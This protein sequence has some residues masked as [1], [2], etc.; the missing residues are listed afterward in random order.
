[1]NV[2]EGM[3]TAVDADEATS[4]AGA[5]GSRDVADAHGTHDSVSMS[6]ACDPA[7]ALKAPKVPLCRKRTAQLVCWAALAVLCTVFSRYLIPNP[8]AY[9][10][11]FAPL[12]V[13]CLLFLLFR[14]QGAFVLAQLKGG[15][16]LLV[17][18][19][20][21]SLMLSCA[22]VMGAW[23]VSE[24]A[25]AVSPLHA[26]AVVVEAVPILVGF[27]LLMDWLDKRAVRKSKRGEAHCSKQEGW[28]SCGEPRCDAIALR[29]NSSSAERPFFS[30][31]PF[32]LIVFAVMV[33]CWLPVFLA[34]YPGFFCYDMT[35]GD[36]AEWDQY[37]VGHFSAHQPVAHTLLLGALITLGS[38][39]FGSFNAGVAA[40]VVV[41]AVVVAAIF[42]F[43]LRR[44]WSL[45]SSRLLTGCSLAYLALD[46]LVSLFV[47]CTTKDVLFSAF[48]VLLATLLLS[49]F[50]RNAPLRIA[51]LLSIGLCAVAVGV[52]RPNGLLAVAVCLPFIILLRKGRREKLKAALMGLSVLVLCATWFGPVAS[53]L[54]VEESPLQ[55][56]NALSLPAQ[57]ITYVVQE[58]ANATTLTELS[59]LTEAGFPERGRAGLLTSLET[60]IARVGTC[61][62]CPRSTCCERGC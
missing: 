33:L 10:M 27:V 60:P 4:P 3:N 42:A 23:S 46:P 28:S 62:K 30:Q 39:I 43:M 37:S 49:A 35:V 17:V 7:G 11:G 5:C 26:V 48:V 9:S 59:M 57:Q 29:D 41:Q 40:C 18:S 52:L 8:L 31:L 54:G 61:W 38:G 36:Y 2:G 24:H 45:T 56:V 22:L 12:L 58:D 16:R 13:A 34:A 14:A 47:C 53:A 55:R 51:D 19:I 15:R 50:S 1:M 20:V 32:T 21:F 25:G 44:I 6:D